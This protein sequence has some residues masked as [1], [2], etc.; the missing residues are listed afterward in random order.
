[1]ER[2]QYPGVDVEARI[3]KR[4]GW[5]GAPQRWVITVALQRVVVAVTA[6]EASSIVLGALEREGE[7][8]KA[9][10]VQARIVA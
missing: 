9:V 8:L 2:G 7:P 3:A 5:G 6:G 4:L 1:M 10:V